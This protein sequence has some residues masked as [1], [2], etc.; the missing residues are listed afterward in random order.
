M[1]A[2]PEQEVPLAQGEFETSAKYR[3]FKGPKW[4]DTWAALLFLAHLG[5]L[6]AAAIYAV[7]SGRVYDKDTWYPWA[8]ADLQPDPGPSSDATVS[9]HHISN[10]LITD[11]STEASAGPALWDRSASGAHPPMVHTK[12]QAVVNAPNATWGQTQTI[13]T[14]A[15]AGTIVVG[16]A[17]VASAWLWMIAQ[18]PLLWLRGLLA[19]YIGLFV[20]MFLG[21]IMMLK[22]APVYAMFVLLLAPFYYLW[23]R[24]MWN[25][26]QFSAI[27]L[28]QSCRTVTGHKMTVG[29]AF[30]MII[31]S[32]FY[33]VV[34]V[35]ASNLTTQAWH[36]APLLVG[37]IWSELIFI[38]I[39][40]TTV[41]GVAATD[42]FVPDG[43]TRPVWGAF[44]RTCTYSL[45]SICFGSA[46]VTLL[47]TLRAVVHMGR[48]Q[49]SQKKNLA[50]ILIA[51]CIE[52]LLGMLESLIEYCNHYAY[53]QVAMYGK[54]FVT[55]AKDTWRL[56]Q[57]SGMDA[58]IN[59][60][61]IGTA[62]GMCTLLSSLVVGAVASGAAYLMANSWWS[63]CADGSAAVAAYTIAVGVPAFIVVLVIHKVVFSALDSA[64]VTFFVC[65]AEE[66]EVLAL[67]H[68]E[69]N[70]EINT[71]VNAYLNSSL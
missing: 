54:S 62:V 53:V 71:R 64:V 61:I 70:I 33:K 26:A 56:V 55:A 44:R 47:R 17:G 38:N 66:P 50:L 4:N 48:A 39:A 41:C 46:V 22:V 40:H 10:A 15:A 32:G 9:M 69:L 3:L 68:P 30:L 13:A 60:M 8:R 35:L 18:H 25:R 57:S 2:A 1:Q 27:I 34:W 49:A 45:G 20:A 65:F 43:V 11:Q 21:Q 16:S 63:D 37:V 42:F 31:V 28:Q 52:C 5:L 23:W 36:L 6:F 7:S 59:D 29:V 67:K 24:L 19:G 58:L 51:C 14:T 12:V